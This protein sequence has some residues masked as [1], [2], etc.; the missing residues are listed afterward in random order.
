MKLCVVLLALLLFSTDIWICFGDEEVNK[1]DPSHEIAREKN[2][3]SNESSTAKLVTYP[4]KNDMVKKGEKQDAV[5]EGGSKN[6]RAD[7]LN[8]DLNSKVV[9][10]EGAVKESKDDLNKEPIVKKRGEEKEGSN[11]ESKSKPKLVDNDKNSFT[12]KESKPLRED[13]TR[14]EECGASSNCTD[15][16]DNLIACLRVPGNESPDL[17]LFIQNKGTSPLTVKILAPDFVN[18]EKSTVHLQDKEDKKVKV[19]FRKGNGDTTLTLKAGDGNCTI[20]FRD[21]ISHYSDREVLYGTK[22]SFTGIL[23]KSPKVLSIYM[24]VAVVL[25]VTPA[26]MCVKYWRKHLKADGSRYQKLE[27]E[28]PTISSKG[29]T[30]QDPNEGWENSWGDS[31]DDE[32]APKTPSKPVTPSISSKRVASRRHSKDGWKD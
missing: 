9:P 5:A 13:S 18:L 10:K 11:G 4:S 27:T 32:E 2:E 14:V 16:K 20:D 26:W 30:E 6:D 8:K 7:S 31:W 23:T 19:S 21:L 22:Y 28:L 12:S 29:N 15:E 24:L 25:L 3:P 1:K 17:S